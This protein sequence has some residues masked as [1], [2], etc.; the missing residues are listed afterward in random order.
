MAEARGGGS[1]GGGGSS[2]VSGGPGRAQLFSTVMDAFLGKL[3][4]AGSYQRFAS[5]YRSFYRLQPEVTKSIHSQF[6][7]QLQA[8]IRAEVQE[9]MDEGNLEALLD[10]LDKIVEEAEPQEEPAWRPSG[11]PEEDARSALVPY[12]LKHRSYL[13]RALKNKEEENK[14]V[15]E[16][17]L[18]GR[19][20]I[21]ELQQ[22]IQAHKR[23]WQ[24]LSKEQQELV[25]TFQQPQ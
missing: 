18:A 20:R 15:A 13:L 21:S 2:S 5:C 25:L 11:I 19:G 17:V 3:V 12:L 22:Q 1:D 16:S 14:K 7:A 23:A 24:A 9:V 10:S 4:A 6:V 8:S